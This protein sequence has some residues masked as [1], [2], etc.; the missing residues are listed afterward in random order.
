MELS[1]FP[2]L[3]NFIV[4]SKLMLDKD[5]VWIGSMKVNNIIFRSIY[6][7]TRDT[8]ELK[9]GL[10]KYIFYPIQEE[11]KRFKYMLHIRSEESDI[12]YAMDMSNGN[13]MKETLNGEIDGLYTK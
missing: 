3:A 2:T 6:R 5:E 9:T 4:N 7:K 13:V 8:L 11:S 1:F 10:D 12:I